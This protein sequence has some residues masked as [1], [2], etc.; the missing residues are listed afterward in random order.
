MGVPTT[1]AGRVRRTV[2]IVLGAL[3]VGLG[4]LGIFLP[5][6]PTTVFL[7]LA[8]YCFA[9]SSPRLN[10]LLLNH[11]HFGPFLE[12]AGRRA[13]SFRAKV[14]SLLAMW[15][16]VTFS[17]VTLTGTGPVAIMVIVSLAATGTAVLLFYVR[18]LPATG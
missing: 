12:N 11:R 9:R 5:G 2:L 10:R 8:S 6:L 17:C 1:Q 7:L 13:M 4:T 18:T 3:S 15:A 16:G 14:I